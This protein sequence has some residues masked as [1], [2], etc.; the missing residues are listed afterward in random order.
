MSL[1]G[2]KELQFR[3]GFNCSFIIHQARDPCRE[4]NVR[5][6]QKIEQFHQRKC[7]LEALSEI[8]EKS[9]TASSSK[10]LCGRC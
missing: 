10:H 3:P 8:T 5:S 9:M 6:V 4:L 2:L 7:L 1:N